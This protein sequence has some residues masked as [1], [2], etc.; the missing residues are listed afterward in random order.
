MYFI[1]FFP[2]ATIQNRHDGVEVTASASQS[3]GLGFISQVQSYQKTLKKGIYSFP[4]WRSAKRNSVENKP[5][6]LLVVS[7]SKT[8]NGM[9]PSL[10]GRQM[11]GQAVYPSW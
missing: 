5:A 1:V 6:S 9:P 7:M 11:M 10:C 2:H 8:L 4:A 3:V